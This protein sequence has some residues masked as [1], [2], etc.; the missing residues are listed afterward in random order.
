L[1]ERTPPRGFPIYYVPW[2]WLS[3]EKKIQ[4]KN[5]W[6]LWLAE[7]NFDCRRLKPF[8]P[9]RLPHTVLDEGT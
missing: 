2:E 4:K 1:I 7:S 9:T 3:L 5:P 8:C 6:G